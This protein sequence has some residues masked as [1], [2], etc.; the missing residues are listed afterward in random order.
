MK[1]SVYVMLLIVF[2]MM[3]C[4]FGGTNA[5]VAADKYPSRP[6]TTMVGFGPG[7]ISDMTMRN[8]EQVS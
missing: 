2:A 6:V 4:C 8:M 7:G 5:A 3:F 1:K